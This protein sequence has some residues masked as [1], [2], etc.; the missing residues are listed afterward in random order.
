ME[1]KMQAHTVRVAS[2]AA[3]VALAT[4]LL[5]GCSGWFVESTANRALPTPERTVWAVCPA[6]D[7]YFDSYEDASG[8]Y[9]NYVYKVDAATEDQEC[10]EVTIILF[11]RKASGEGW[12]EIQA[13]GTAG[14]HYDSVGEDD[15]PEEAIEALA[16]LDESG[17]G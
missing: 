5:S 7:D 1:F 6:P 11:G 4:C 8:S 14:V 3:A 9:M 16:A 2:L 15:V 13:K 10:I 12:L 17:N